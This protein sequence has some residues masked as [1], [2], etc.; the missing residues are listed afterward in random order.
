M[1]SS[2]GGMTMYNPVLDNDLQF[3]VQLNFTT[4][5]VEG[6]GDDQVVVED[7]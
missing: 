2:V 7:H 4:T 3:W 1:F 5:R 6:M